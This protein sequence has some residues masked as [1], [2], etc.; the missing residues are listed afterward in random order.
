M[1]EVVASSI[2]RF[3]SDK[4]GAKVLNELGLLK[5]VGDELKRLESTLAA[6]QDVLEDAEARQVKEK[7]LGVWLRKLKD[8]AYDLDDLLDETAVKA[9]TKGKVRGL[10]LT[11]K[12][13][14]VRHD[15]TRKVKGMRKRLDAI[16]EERAIFHL[17]EG[18]AKDSEVGSGVREQTG[19]LVDESQVYGRQQDK[20]QILDFL[21]GDC[22]EHNNNL[23][24]IAIVGLGGLG[25]TTLA[26]LVY[27]D[28]EVHQQFERRM[29]VYVSDK[30]DSKSL[31]RSIIES[32]SAKEFTLPD[33]DP[34]QRELVKQIRGRRF[35]LVLD[36]VWN[37][38]Y[39]LWDRLRL[40]LN[41]GAKG[42]KV[43]VTTRS[44]RVAS[45]MNADQ[46]HFL[47]G[48]S[49]DDCWLLFERRA[50]ESGSSS[51][52]PS[53][54]A[55]G[56]EIVRRCGG[57][58]LA[59]KALG[60]MMRFKR[61]VS[62]WVA[63]RDNEIWRSSADGDDDQILPAL[64]LSYS[65]LPPR[66]KQCFAYCAMIPK[67]ETM[68]IRTL[69]R[70]W[71]AEGLADLEDVG[72][73]YVDQLLSRSLL[74]IRQEEAHGAVSLVKMHDVVHDLARFVAGDECSVVDVR[75]ST[76]ISPG[77]RYASLL[78]DGR[79]PSVAE[80]LSHLRKLRALYV[81]VTEGIFEKFGARVV[82]HKN[83]YQRSAE[84]QDE[85]ERVLLAI[86]ST[87]KPLR[88]LHLDSFPMKALPAAVQNLDHLRY[89]DLSGT[90]LR[91]LPQVI[92]RLHNLQILK[93][94]RCTGVEALPESIGELVNLVTLDLCC[95][96]RLSSLPDSIGR[97]GNL[98]N[99]DVSW[100]CITTL[101]ESLSSLS[102]LQLLKL[103][104]CYWLHELPKNAQSMRSLTHL[105]I[106]GCY[107]LTCMPA[108]LGQLRQLRMLPMYLLGD[109]EGDGGLEEIGTLNLEGELYIG[110]LQ[111]LRSVA[112]AGESNLRE[113]RGLRS[114]KLNWDL[115]SWFQ[116][117]DINDVA[118]MVEEH[119]E[120]AED[121][122][123]S[124]RP[125]PDLEELRI[126]GYVGKVLPGWMMDCSIP[127]LVELS[128]VS[129]VRCEKLPAL[130]RLS[131]L[132]VLKLIR[133][134]CVECLPQLGQLPCLRVLCLGA[135]PGV[136]RLGSELYG[137]GSAFPALE[138]LRLD[139]MSDLEEWS[140]TEG[141]DFLPRLSE[142]ELMDCPKLEA[143]PST[144]PSVNRLT[145]NV[146]DKLLLSHLE[147]GAFPNLKHLGICNCDVADDADMPEVL[148]ERLAS[149]ESSSRI[150][151][152][153]TG[154]GSSSASEVVMMT[155][156]LI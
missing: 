72:S 128:L 79:T 54:V 17:R 3:V 120:F 20:A 60:S 111:N 118:A 19:S 23:G 21:L 41:N 91:T 26:Q 5:G 66:L 94:Q 43:V 88:A 98:R 112:E 105:D 126:E 147:R 125:Q 9:L 57:M 34:M 144:F 71:V 15:I 35:L 8:V 123:G 58:P 49:D 1:A 139:S 56:K 115:A 84:E 78:F 67:G 100:S 101:P 45:V 74:E 103:R 68:R 2:L 130:E 81:I 92:G 148:V 24:V 70:L 124:L 63:V 151:R 143:L 82:D 140:G 155:Q 10:P 13:I 146:D 25:K 65:H 50:F 59:A 53:L 73:Q 80:T 61:E 64:M 110:N 136:K 30:F 156:L 31:M 7:S 109:G 11:P 133:F 93:L 39:E 152:P 121:A 52:N 127:N 97:M 47:A 14:R 75:G 116:Q 104:D 138:E 117:E 36:D 129:F 6:I 76:A 95:C 12:S 33:M 42:S 135:L 132:K 16:A 89:L 134:P 83:F 149:V 46:V 44:R 99:L 62:Q 131:C 77:S 107:G 114:L 87:M 4:L 55:I 108:G 18:T 29:W 51:R 90:D 122:L 69:A 86:F 85:D 154:S 153:V 106:H 22:T 150:G 37:E 113:K 38:D 142:L 40:L 27:N 32:L 28:E 48:L 102:N 119:T 145:M 96:R 141:E 137:G